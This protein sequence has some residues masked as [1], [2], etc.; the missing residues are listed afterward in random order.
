MIA[1]IGAV[2]EEVQPLARR[3]EL[4]CIEQRGSLYV[5]RHA[6]SRGDVLL[7]QS[8]MGREHAE[9]ACEH[10]IGAYPV[11]ELLSIG[12]SGALRDGLSAGDVLLCS[13]V[14][15]DEEACGDGSRATSDDQLTQRIAHTLELAGTPVGT[16]RCITCAN[17]LSTPAGKHALADRWGVD[18]VDMEAGWIARI[19]ARNTIPFAALRVVSDR[20]GDTLPPLG[21][22]SVDLGRVSRCR[23]AV[24]AACRPRSLAALLRLAVN[25]RRAQRSL[26][27]AV[28]AIVDVWTRS[29]EG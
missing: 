11:D 19:A 7:V 8:G 6:A 24:R 13:D 17:V 3:L 25:V 18:V 22:G 26:A 28:D 4:S 20:V 15:I 23:I 5:Y 1:I 27:R 21:D 9:E 12:F 2:R 16:G 14:R 29:E 10:V